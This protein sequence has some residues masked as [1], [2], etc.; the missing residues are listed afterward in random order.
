MSTLDFGLRNKF[1]VV[2]GSSGHIG[3]ALCQSLADQG[4]NVIG[5]D[6]SN[7]VEGPI[8]SEMF[9]SVDLGDLTALD[10]V[11]SDI[12]SSYPE[13]QGLVHSAAFVGTSDLTGWLG[14]I[15]QQSRQTFD[16]AMEVNAG[17]AFSLVKGLFESLQKKGASVVL[18]SSIYGS[19]GPD[20][21]LY[22]GTLMDNPIAYGM[23]KA[24]LDQLARY[25]ACRYG[26]FNI[27]A[28]SIVLGGVFRNQP[29]AFV[30]KYCKKTPLQRMAVES[31]VIGPIC[32]LLSDASGYVSGSEIR[33]D[34]GYLAT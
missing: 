24:A 1:V 2:T 23:S 15:Q 31:D 12:T 18:I 28:N 20:M 33:V 6:R 5:I 7:I 34:G 26:K 14:G 8:P 27:R 22:E 3:R 11:L 32:F 19:V 30:E 10:A 13:I 17:S 25:V 21:S 16:Q 29:E 4:V 9:Y